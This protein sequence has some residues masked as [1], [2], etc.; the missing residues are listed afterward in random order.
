MEVPMSGFL[1]YLRR[2]GG[3]IGSCVGLQYSEHPVEILS[4]S[5]GVSEV[6]DADF[7]TGP[8]KY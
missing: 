3:K 7:P 6:F 5:S 8:T 1:Q 4:V 2:W